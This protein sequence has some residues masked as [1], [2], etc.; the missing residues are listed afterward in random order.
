MDKYPV[1]GSY[2][3]QSVH[4]ITMTF[5]S[6]DYV[7]TIERRMG[8]NCM[9]AE[10]LESVINELCEVEF[11]QELLDEHDGVIVLKNPSGDSTIIDDPEFLSL[12]LVKAEITAYGGKSR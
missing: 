11:A 12:C 2:P 3:R 10:V 8:G 1:N 4:T 6:D 5:M 9:G 7:G